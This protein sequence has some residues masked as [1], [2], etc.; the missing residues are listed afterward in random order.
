[1]KTRTDILNEIRW[2]YNYRTYLEIGVDYAPLNFDRIVCPDKVGVDPNP[3]ANGTH[4]MTSDVFFAQCTQTFDLVF[5]DG[6]HQSG[7]C[8]QDVLNALKHLDE[9]GTIVIHDCNPPDEQ[10]QTEIQ[11]QNAWTGDVWKAWVKLRAE[12]SDLWMG[13]VDT[14]YGVGVIQRGK[15][16]PITLKYPLTYSYLDNNRDYLLNL[17]DPQTYIDQLRDH[18]N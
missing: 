11:E 4:C 1:M 9:D 2:K 3:K 5:I 17:L 6:L 15:Q 12:R 10:H 14:D 16:V 8:Y 18:E 13:V 7:Q